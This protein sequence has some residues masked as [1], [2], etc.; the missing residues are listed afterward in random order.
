MDTSV[1]VGFEMKDSSEH[2]Y[3]FGWRK[4]L[5]LLLVE[6]LLSRKAVLNL[7]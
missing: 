3:P 7:H 4:H 6:M 1:S 5:Y 2:F